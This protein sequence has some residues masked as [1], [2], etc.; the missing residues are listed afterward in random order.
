MIRICIRINC[1]D[2]ILLNLLLKSDRSVQTVYSLD[3]TSDNH[4]KA[5][6]GLLTTQLIHIHAD[7]NAVKLY[8]LFIYAEPLPGQH[9]T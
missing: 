9:S 6:F 4:P 3:F 7:W 2:C 1:K 5:P 8:I